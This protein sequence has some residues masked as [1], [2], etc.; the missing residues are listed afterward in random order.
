MWAAS[1]VFFGLF[2]QS[3][4][5]VGVE[6][7]RLPFWQGHQGVIDNIQPGALSWKQ[8]FH[9]CFMKLIQ[10]Q[11]IDTFFCSKDDVLIFSIWMNP[12]CCTVN[13]Q[14]APIEDFGETRSHQHLWR[15]WQTID[16][17][18]RK[19]SSL[20]YVA[21]EG[22]VQI[23]LHFPQWVSTCRPHSQWGKSQSEAHRQEYSASYELV[24]LC[25][26]SQGSVL[27]SQISHHPGGFPQGN[28][29]FLA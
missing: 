10:I 1:P 8:L 26:V 19:I 13:L 18:L 25:S 29:L 5:I 11:S 12:R 7:E 16:C 28:C 14:R 2:K 22:F 4:Q 6:L 24:G 17:W 3:Y 15:W 9:C 20:F 27:S 23:L 21:A